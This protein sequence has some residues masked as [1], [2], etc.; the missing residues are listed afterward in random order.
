LAAL[1]L[2][3]AVAGLAGTAVSAVGAVEQGQATAAN[4]SY[5]AQV[6]RNNAQI[7]NQNA[8]WTTES[9]EAQAA[10]QGE[11]AKAA[12]GSVVAAQG[13]DNVDVN[14]GSAEQVSSGA[15]S[16]ANLDTQTIMSNAARGAYGYRVAATSDT[17]QAGLEEQEASQATTAG[18]ISSLGSFLSGISSVGGNWAK[19]QQF[20]T[21]ATAAGASP[22][23]GNGTWTL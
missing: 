4:A 18:D 5:Q 10:A 13:A 22:N 21:G 12:V 2:I 7:A 16:L 19:Y 6:A 17:A 1:P 9:G 8:A 20:G 3:A 15:K 23:V 11:K 14:T